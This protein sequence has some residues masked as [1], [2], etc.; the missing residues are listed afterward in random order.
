M[1]LC[2]LEIQLRKD[3]S[4]IKIDLRH[5]VPTL[6]IYIIYL[7]NLRNLLLCCIDCLKSVYHK[8]LTI[9]MFSSFTSL[10]L[11]QFHF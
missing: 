2:C 5:F 1:N 4:A 10:C 11:R 3:L 6:I 7:Y 9:I 8:N